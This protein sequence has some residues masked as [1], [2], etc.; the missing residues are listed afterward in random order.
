MDY[1]YCVAILVAVMVGGEGRPLQQSNKQSIRCDGPRR[2]DLCLGKLKDTN[3][4]KAKSINAN[5]SLIN[6]FNKQINHGSICSI[7]RYK[8]ITRQCN[9]LSKQQS[10]YQY[11]DDRIRSGNHMKLHSS[12]CV[13]VRRKRHLQVPQMP[14]KQRR[15]W[16]CNRHQ[17]RAPIPW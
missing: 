10:K 4:T 15:L 11:C 13:G 17:G 16:D 2:A 12:I 3:V 14:M 7:N 5:Q 8:S 9:H 6:H 1:I